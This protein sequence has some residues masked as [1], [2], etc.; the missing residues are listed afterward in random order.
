MKIFII[1]LLALLSSNGIQANPVDEMFGAYQQ[2]GVISTDGEQGKALWNKAF[3]TE[4]SK[5]K[6]RSCASCHGSNVRQNGEHIRTGKII[7]PMATSVNA[8][9]FT[10]TKKIKKWFKRNCKWTLGRECSAQEQ[11][12]ILKYL[13]TQ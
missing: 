11:A 5:G 13:I 4:K 10:D 9:R 1:V 3:I 8:K 6:E 2:A 7:E 12:D